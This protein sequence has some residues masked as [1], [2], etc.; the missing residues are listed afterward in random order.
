M[1]KS[2]YVIFTPDLGMNTK[3]S[4]TW[5]ILEE[6]MKK[7]YMDD[8]R[9][10]Q[11]A[12]KREHE[13]DER[14]LHY[15]VES[16]G[17]VLFRLRSR[18]N[19]HAPLIPEVV[20]KSFAYHISS[21]LLTTDDALQ[22]LHHFCS[23]LGSGIYV[24]M[25]PQFTFKE[26]DNGNVIA[27][28]ILPTL[29]DP[30]FRTAR[31]AY[32]WRTERMAKNDAAFQAYK[33]LHIGGLVNENLLP[34]RRAEDEEAKEFQIADNTPSLVKVP[35]AFDP[36]ITVAR[37]QQNGHQTYL[38]T[39]LTVKAFGE[40]PMYLV[41]LT[42]TILPQLPQTPLYWNKSK[43]FIVNSSRLQDV[44]LTHE[45]LIVLK[46]ITQAILYPAFPGRVPEDRKDFLWLLAPLTSPQGIWDISQL[47]EW[48][49]LIKG[50]KSAVARLREEKGTMNDWGLI[51]IQGHSRRYIVKD[52]AYDADPSGTCLK[53]MRLP[54]R[55]DFLHPVAE[56]NQQNE[57]YTT[58]ESFDAS[59]CEV[60]NLPSIYPI[61]ALFVP[62]IIH[63]FEVYMTADT[64]RTTLLRPISFEES[65]LSIL[66]K[67][68]TSSAASDKD[69]YQRLE[70][71]GD[72]ILK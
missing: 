16:T 48:H 38:R 47:Q 72:C 11:E 19:I 6:E 17:Y 50:H 8:L 54:K 33:S 24:D 68:I 5:E 4:E 43:E 41:L 20:S 10:A 32:S 63:R 55:R 23:L 12:E 22:H 56:T 31:S 14:I 35:P 1:Q 44:L 66:V 57:M 13:D 25:R 70:F 45:E 30:A 52:I 3:S 34:H 29:V 15:Q 62:S 37:R 65:T 53:V 7:A 61:L 2:K 49:S 18:E 36:W 67:A 28:V 71:L 60:E 9:K 51:N 58:T 64:L 46:E 59:I 69:N 39:L 42:P 26:D 27:E 21:A 40:D